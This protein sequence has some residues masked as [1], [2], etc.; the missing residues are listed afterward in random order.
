VLQHHCLGANLKVLVTGA[1][2]LLG[3]QLVQDLS[4]YGFSVTAASRSFVARSQLAGVS[5]LSG[6]LRDESFVLRIFEDRFDHV[7][8]CAGV[9]TSAGSAWFSSR[10]VGDPIRINSLCLDYAAKSGVS[11]FFLLSSTTIYPTMDSPCVEDK[12][13][14]KDPDP[15]YLSTG[16]MY[17]LLEKLA[18]DT[19]IRSKLGVTIIRPTNIY[20]PYD[21]FLGPNSQVIPALI[22]TFSE[23][24]Q[25]YVV[26]GDGTQIRDFVYVKDVSRAVVD[27]LIRDHLDGPFNIGSGIGTRIRELASIIA[28][29]FHVPESSIVYDSSKPINVMYRVAD[30]TYAKQKIGFLPTY[31]LRH[32]LEETV[33]WYLQSLR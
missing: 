7:I 10:T 20:G 21:N 13:F 26:W 28:S 6:D 24:S 15:A 9:K 17:R 4:D 14:D 31:S 12:G 29:L 30:I 25:P 22:K 1:G 8:Q 23:S 18:R 33:Q 3:T 11:R 2:G 32:G 19:S 27:L 16:W 5:Y